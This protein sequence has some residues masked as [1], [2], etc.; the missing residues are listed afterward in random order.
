MIKGV[1]CCVIV[2]SVCSTLSVFAQKKMS[3]IHLDTGQFNTII[4][5]SI[6]GEPRRVESREVSNSPKI[7]QTNPQ[8]SVKRLAIDG[9]IDTIDY[10]LNSI[11]TY[12]LHKPVAYNA[13]SPVASVNLRTADI[14]EIK[15]LPKNTYFHG[16]YESGILALGVNGGE[17]DHSSEAQQD[18]G[19]LYYEELTTKVWKV[20][21]RTENA[22]LLF[23][24][25]DRLPVS[26]DADINRVYHTTD[27]DNLLIETSIYESTDRYDVKYFLYNTVSD[28][29]S[30]FKAFENL[31]INFESVRSR[32]SFYDMTGLFIF[33]PV[34]QH[35]YNE[36]ILN[37][38][39]PFNKVLLFDRNFNYLQECLPRKM[40]IVGYNYEKDT[41]VSVN[42]RSELD[43]KNSRWDEH[44]AEAII[45]YPLTI[46]IEK[47]LYAIYRN[48]EL[49][50]Y[51]IRRLSQEQ[52]R[53]AKNMVFARH[54]YQFDSPYYQ[55]FFNLFDFYRTEDMRKARTKTMEGKLSYHD[56]RNLKLLN[57]NIRN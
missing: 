50:S 9:R 46:D 3:K 14:A 54:N 56:M 28:E 29:V 44:V 16:L 30:K 43:I 8:V 25:N 7:K 15:I 20:N 53:L 42:L 31:D 41:A 1:L 23:D 11:L 51:D 57:D 47:V 52:L 18:G 22:E 33:V 48:Q 45:A 2:L 34:S 49:S 39:K 19:T 21:S 40:Q 32:D 27:L 24:I 13:Q 37:K 26:E 4:L 17:Y 36:V 5:W 6:N 10:G 55:A 38:K 35:N 12:D